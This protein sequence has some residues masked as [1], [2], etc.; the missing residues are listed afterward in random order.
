MADQLAHLMGEMRKEMKEGGVK[1]GGEGV[2]VA[3]CW[4]N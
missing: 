3:G 4:T 1:E 2:V